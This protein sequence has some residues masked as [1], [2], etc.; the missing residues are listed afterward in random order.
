[1]AFILGVVLIAFGLVL[2]FKPTVI[3]KIQSYL[4]VKD[5][6]PTRFYDTVARVSGGLAIAIGILVMIYA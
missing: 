5:G 6:E 2:I 4:F 1:M 3:W